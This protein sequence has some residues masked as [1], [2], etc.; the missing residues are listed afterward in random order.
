MS[1]DITWGYSQT[2][3][4]DE[5]RLP[6]VMQHNLDSGTLLLGHYSYPVL[7]LALPEPV[8]IDHIR[9]TYFDILYLLV[10]REASHM[11]NVKGK[12][13]PCGTCIECP[14]I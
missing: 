12:P 4:L 13:S 8:L 14:I 11:S 2:I 7:E 1:G 6:P 3:L 10:L 5:R 9:H